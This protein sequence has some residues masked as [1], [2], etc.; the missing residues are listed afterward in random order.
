MICLQSGGAIEG[1]I[2]ELIGEY[3]ALRVEQ[4][5][6]YFSIEDAQMEKIIRKLVKKG[7]LVSDKEN[8]YIKASEQKTYDEGLAQCF[9]VV[10]DL[11]EA[12]EFH[13]VG[14]YPLLI[15]VYANGEAYEIYSCKKGDEMF[16]CHVIER[17]QEKVQGKVLIVLEDTEQIGKLLIVLEDT[18]QI[19]KLQGINCIFC[20][21]SREGEVRYYESSA[22]ST[23]TESPA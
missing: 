14:R 20:T 19:G 21:V 13:A 7:R 3:G 8:G 18:E 1:K 15:A 2:V 5:Q 17:L 4:L 16:L 22:V 6:R 11:K 23:E 10:L 12:I 9:W